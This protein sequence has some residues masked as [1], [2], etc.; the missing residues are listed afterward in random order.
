VC[1]FVS[2]CVCV[3][4]ESGLLLGGQ[5]VKEGDQGEGLWWMDFISS[6][7]RQKRNLL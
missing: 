3:A 2:F 7:D 4:G 1:V 6:W 5:R